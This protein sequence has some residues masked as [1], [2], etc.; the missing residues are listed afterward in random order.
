MLMSVQLPASHSAKGGSPGMSP[1]KLSLHCGVGQLAG[2]K[3]PLPAGRATPKLMFTQ[4]EGSSLPPPNS[5]GITTPQ[6]MPAHLLCLG[7]RSMRVPSATW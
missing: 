7:P 5:G 1:W 4:T 3:P 6:V 2:T